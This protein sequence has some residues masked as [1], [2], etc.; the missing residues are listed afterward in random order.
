M[1]ISANKVSQFSIQMEH[2]LVGMTSANMNGGQPIS[3]MMVVGSR[4]HW[5]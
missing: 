4:L 3:T 1:Q 2:F 5:H